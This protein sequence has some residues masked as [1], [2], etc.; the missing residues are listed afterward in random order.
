[1]TVYCVTYDLN[2]PG[3]K[4]KEVSDYLKQFAYCKHL[5]SF[6]LIDTSKTAAQIRDDLKSKV[7]ANDMVFVARLQG[8]W[9]SWNYGCADWLNDSKRNW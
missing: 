3:Q 8:S 7:D 2:S 5:E 6:W 4:Y 1:M 9:A